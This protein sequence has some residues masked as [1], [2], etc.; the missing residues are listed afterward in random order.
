[1]CVCCVHGGDVRAVSLLVLACAVSLLVCHGGDVSAVPDNYVCN[2]SMNVLGHHVQSDAGAR[3]EWRSMRG[4]LWG[5]FWKNAGN[6]RISKQSFENKAKLLCR[7]VYATFAWKFGRWPYQKSI[8]V[9]MDQMQ[10]KMVSVL[11]HLPF[12]PLETVEGYCRRK[13]KLAAQLCAKIGRWSLLWAAKVVDW[14]AH[15]TRSEQYG[16][17]TAKLVKYHD[18]QWL[19]HKRACWVAEH[20]SSSSRVTAVAGRTG[21]RL[22]IGQ[23]QTRWEEGLALARSVMQSRESTLIGNKSLSIGSRIR[24]AMKE[25]HSFF[26]NQ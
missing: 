12:G 16:S 11:I 17:M 2:Q 22:N 4:K 24:N 13:N 5:C 8:A 25:T 15:V 19:F 10:S 6:R 23:P 7:S 20:A 14:H 18:A 1:V 26:G 9:E 3:A 21:T